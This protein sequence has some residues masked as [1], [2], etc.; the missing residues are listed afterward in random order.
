LAPDWNGWC[1]A[2]D[3]VETVFI[4]VSENQEKM[5]KG[6]KIKGGAS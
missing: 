6:E 3:A 1:S 4:Y 5:A 2:G